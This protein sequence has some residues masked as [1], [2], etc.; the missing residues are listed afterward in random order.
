MTSKDGRK[1]VRRFYSAAALEGAKGALALEYEALAG[2]ITEAAR[3][4]RL[5]RRFLG[6]PKSGSGLKTRAEVAARDA[7]IFLRA[8]SKALNGGRRRAKA[9]EERL[10]ALLLASLEHL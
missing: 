4:V 9:A 5:A 6:A 8:A 3:L 7:D 1:K 10:T 2:A